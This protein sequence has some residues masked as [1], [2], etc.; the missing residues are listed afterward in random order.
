MISMLSILTSKPLYLTSYPRYLC[1][2][3]HY[4]DHIT[5]T[6]LMRSHP[7]YMM[8]SYPLYTTTYSQYLQHHN[9]C[10]CVSHPLFLSYHTLCIYDIA[11]TIC[12]TSDTF[13]KVSHPQ[14]MTSRHNIYDITCT[15]FMLPL[16]RYLTLHPQYLCPHIPSQYDL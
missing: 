10:T 8:T 16:P 11:S 13:Y 2:H 1:Q 9:H 15:V 6:V 12:V 4:I 5:P 7:L 14:F 3:I